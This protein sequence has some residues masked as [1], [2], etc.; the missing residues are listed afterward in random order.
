MNIERLKRDLNFEI[1]KNQF[2]VKRH[3]KL[4]EIEYYVHLNKDKVDVDY[5]INLILNN[6][7]IAKH[8]GVHKSVYN[9]TEDMEEN[10]W[11][12]TEWKNWNI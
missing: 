1:F 11:K 3:K 8:G 9:P 10:E 2:Y 4:Q 6:K 12:K 5:L 7:C